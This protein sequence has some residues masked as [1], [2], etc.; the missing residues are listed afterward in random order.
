MFSQKE[1]DSKAKKQSYSVAGMGTLNKILNL[2]SV[3]ENLG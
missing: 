2:L 1:R 3:D